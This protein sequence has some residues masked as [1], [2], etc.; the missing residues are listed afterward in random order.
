VQNASRMFAFL[1]A[2]L[3]SALASSL[4]W[5]PL[6]IGASAPA[7]A[8]EAAQST[9]GRAVA[10]APV[11][12][13]Q[14]RYA[15]KLPARTGEIVEAEFRIYVAAEGGD[16]L[17]TETQRV[18]V[19]E[20][21]SYSVLLGGAS[22]AGLSQTVFAGGAAR[23]LGV[24][25]ERSAEQERVLLSSVPYAMKSADAESLAG[26]AAS[27]FVTQE[28][29][30]QL[31]QSS[32]P[33]G[34]KGAAPPDVQPDT[35]GTVTGSGTNGTIPLWTGA[36]TQGNS[37]ISQSGAN[38]SIG[39]S[40]TGASLGVYG[41]ISNVANGTYA[42]FTSSS[43]NSTG[44]EGSRIAFNR[45]DGT[46]VAPTVV[47]SNDTVGWFD[48]FGYDGSAVQRVGQFSMF[49]DAA[50]SSGIVPGRFQI[51][52]AS[53][54]GVDT[55]RLIAYSNDN[56]ALST[57]G[58]SVG[59]GTTA[60]AAKLEV[61]GTAKFDGNITFASSQ[62]FPIK[63]TGGG[64]ITSVA[65]T[66][67]LTGSATSGAVTIGLSTANLESSLNSV[68]AQLSAA[69]TFSQ[70]ITFASGQT[71]PGPVSTTGSVNAGSF[72]LGGSL[73]AYGN[74]NGNSFLGF[75]GNGSVPTSVV[76]TAVGYEAMTGLTGGAS[77]TAVGAN[78]LDTI[79]TGNLNTALGAYS[80]ADSSNL[81]DSTAIGANAVVSQNDSLVLGRTTDGSPG[82]TYVTVGIGTSTPASE[83][84]LSKSASGGL[85]PVLTLTNPA[86]DG[87]W[88]AIDF[89]TYLHQSTMNS[90]TARIL[91]ADD[92][93]YGTDL[94]FI[95]K[96]PGSDSNG[97][98]DNMI[99]HSNGQV[100]IGGLST[101]AHLTVQGSSGS[102]IGV[103]GAVGSGKGIMGVNTGNS[104]T[105]DT[106]Y[107]ANGAAG[108]WGDT[109]ATGVAGAGIAAVAGTADNAP[110]AFFE[111]SS[112]KFSAVE[113]YNTGGGSGLFKVFKA[114]T[115]VGTC[116]IGDGD[117]SCTGQ[118]KSLVTTGGGA[119]K[120]ET[121]TMQ[122]PENW[123]EDF[124]SGALE[125]GVAVVKIDPAFAET[126]SADVSYHVFITP[127]GDAE[128]LYVINKTATSFEVRESKGGTSSLTFDYRIV[129]KRRGYEAQRL[130]D[131]TERFNAESAQAMPHKADG[132][133]RDPNPQ[134]VP[135]GTPGASG[136]Q[137]TP[138]V[139]PRTRPSAL[140]FGARHPAPA[141][142]P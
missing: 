4:I 124:G 75:A 131:V 116:G 50:P 141:I 136:S 38:V 70:P 2:G 133:P 26:H 125:R 54:T 135:L 43:Y 15:G 121:Y 105:Y 18:T 65:T 66:T 112:S 34:Q 114:S 7:A 78:A 62:T 85:G 68:Y 44:Y 31:A 27:D 11:V 53:A 49:V 10:A 76:N 80:G 139:L 117:L 47:K 81:S 119:R 100:S 79:S 25:V 120:V 37:V 33:S 128:A 39:A 20:D 130:T 55:P 95:S 28:Q 59:I 106:Y 57:H 1:G 115:A 5:I 69:N 64:T 61:N 73:F 138:R 35:S 90:P 9:E 17:W 86:G 102:P 123:M 104:G 32:V 82:K 21:G 36:L 56:I 118:M 24:S 3:L 101:V 98:Q 94:Y 13:Q 137:G 67:P 99:I 107:Q 84:E 140:T 46:Q 45:Y 8:Q 113:A 103:Y 87:A 12:P 142:H 111:N 71:F 77:N 22:P 60:P 134:R 96:T 42:N 110:A 97:L 92:N 63:G 48:F 14:V 51:N 132:A 23:W 52:T 58:G 108:V 74:Q 41:N 91:A 122:S 30:T 16:P 127:N 29:L 40:V 109:S 6:T 88:A 93:N 83:L 126:V 19:G 129:A 72:E 89:K